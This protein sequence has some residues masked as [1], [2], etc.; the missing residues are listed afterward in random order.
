MLN[1]MFDP[2]DVIGIRQEDCYM[3]RMIAL[4]KALLCI[5]CDTIFT[6]NEHKIGSEKTYCPY[7]GSK[8]VRY[9]STFLNRKE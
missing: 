2:R 9:I 3:P 4:T 6:K 8:T 5:D 7:C 1:K